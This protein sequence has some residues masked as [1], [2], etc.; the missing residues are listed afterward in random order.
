MDHD[1]N[2]D[3]GAAPTPPWWRTASGAAM[4]GFLL[5]AG[6]YLLTEH[7]AHFW[8]VLPFLLV[9][10]CPLMHLFHHHGHEKHSAGP[11]PGQGD[12]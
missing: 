10:S 6:F 2:L 8:G 4:C 3:P 11:P 7:T 5:V 9:L 1:K 12:A